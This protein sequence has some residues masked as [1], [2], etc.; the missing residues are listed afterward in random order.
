MLLTLILAG[1]VAV[2]LPKTGS[3]PANYRSE[4]SYCVPMDGKSPVAIPKVGQ[5]PSSMIQSG[6]YCIEQPGRH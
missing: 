2:P 3:C 1:A 6:A 4:A 5:C